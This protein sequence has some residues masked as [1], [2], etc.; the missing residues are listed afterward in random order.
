MRVIKRDHTSHNE[1]MNRA[2][3][4]LS[5]DEKRKFCDYEIINDNAHLVIPQVLQ[6]HEAL[7]KLAIPGTRL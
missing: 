6:L 4:Q 7:L 2:N 1:A 3:K 5:D